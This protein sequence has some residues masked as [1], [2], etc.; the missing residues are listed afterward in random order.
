MLRGPSRDG[1]R[2]GEP[3]I[4][5][6]NGGLSSGE[7]TDRYMGKWNSYVGTAGI[8]IAWE[9]PADRMAACMLQQQLSEKSPQA[10][11]KV[12]TI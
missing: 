3:T 8:Q 7:C 6:F 9:L 11:N 1:K 4:R 5:S 2:S 12:S 10:V